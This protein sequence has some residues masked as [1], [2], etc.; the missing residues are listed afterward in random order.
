MLD[1]EEEGGNEGDEDTPQMSEVKL[2]RGRRNNGPIGGKGCKSQIRPLRIV[3]HLCQ[4]VLREKG[5]LHNV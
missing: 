2:K 3:R 4:L 5:V 1:G